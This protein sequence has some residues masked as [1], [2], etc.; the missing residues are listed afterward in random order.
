MCACQILVR[1]QMNEHG[2]QTLSS[3]AQSSEMALGEEVS[4]NI[5]GMNVG[6]GH[7]FKKERLRHVCLQLKLDWFEKNDSA[8]SVYE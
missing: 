3:E 5:S 7:V 8:V 1:E 2:I 4:G 6:F